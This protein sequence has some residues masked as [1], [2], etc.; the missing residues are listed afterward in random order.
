MNRTAFSVL[1]SLT[2]AGAIHG[3][4]Q[5]NGNEHT[6][7]AADAC[8][9]EG[10]TDGA[11]PPIVT[12]AGPECKQ[13]CSDDLTSV[14]DCAGNV[15]STCGAGLACGSDLG[16]HPPCEAASSL[17]SSMGCNYVVSPPMDDPEF[18][19]SCYTVLVANAWS[20]PVQLTASYGNRTLDLS[21]I[22]RIPTGSGSGLTLQPLAADGLHP[23]QLAVLFL[24]DRAQVDKGSNSTACPAGITAGITDVDVSFHESGVRQAFAITSTGPV[25]AYDM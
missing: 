25:V 2:A 24:A 6:D 4:A 15:V 21:K 8:G 20:T 9:G 12:D 14:V 22:A 10:C 3:C 11:P 19:G 16:C 18:A 7:D 13:G 1:A 23:G 17:K 5:A